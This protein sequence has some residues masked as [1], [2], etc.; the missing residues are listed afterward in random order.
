MPSNQFVNRF[1]NLL[2][3]PPMTFV[4]WLLSFKLH[5]APVKTE[6]PQRS[7]PRKNAV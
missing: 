7:Y 3:N 5:T 6:R 2:V 4:D 1:V